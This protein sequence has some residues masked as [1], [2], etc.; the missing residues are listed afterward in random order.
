MAHTGFAVLV[1]QV[2]LHGLELAVNCVLAMRVPM[3][4]H[5]VERP[6]AD[7]NGRQLL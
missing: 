1:N 3:K 4:L 5:Q 7:L 6:A 2:Q